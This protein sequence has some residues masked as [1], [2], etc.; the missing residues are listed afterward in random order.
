MLGHAVFKFFE[1]NFEV[2]RADGHFHTFLFF[3][4]LIMM[5]VQPFSVHGVERV[6]HDLQPVDGQNNAAHDAN[7]ALGHKAIPAR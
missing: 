2:A 5:T 4:K 7:G 1:I 3:E 6:L